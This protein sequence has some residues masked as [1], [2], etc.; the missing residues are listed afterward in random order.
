MKL[1]LGQ[2]ITLFFALAVTACL[3]FD[4]PFIASTAEAAPSAQVVYA[5]IFD[6][7][8]IG[9]AAGRIDLPLLLLELL[10]VVFVGGAIFFAASQ[11]KNED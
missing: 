8:L 5:S 11:K 9:S 1:N 6:P 2:L 7:P 3:I 10:F 4:A